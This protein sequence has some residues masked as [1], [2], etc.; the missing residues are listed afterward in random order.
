M[1]LKEN[2]EKHM[3]M[4]EGGKGMNNVVIAKIK[5]KII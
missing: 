4:L 2:N 1:K 5:E 3:E